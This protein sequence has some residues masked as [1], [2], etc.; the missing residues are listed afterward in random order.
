MHQH[1][2][3]LT[4]ILKC[5]KVKSNQNRLNHIMLETPVDQSWECITYLDKHNQRMELISFLLRHQLFASIGLWLDQYLNEKNEKKR[6]QNS[7][8]NNYNRLK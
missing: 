8:D 2:D 3:L 6:I 5:I 7:T 4:Q 1:L